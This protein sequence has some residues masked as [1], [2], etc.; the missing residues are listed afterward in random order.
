MTYLLSH[1]LV[2]YIYLRWSKR[3]PSGFSQM[4]SSS[5]SKGGG[6]GRM[7]EIGAK[8]SNFLESSNSMAEVI[9]GGGF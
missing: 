5:F 3:N 4:S 9:P 8:A 6:A 7:N 2:S 1:M